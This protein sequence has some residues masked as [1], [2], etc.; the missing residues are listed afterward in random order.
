MM[1]RFAEAA[2][3]DPSDSQEFTLATAEQVFTL[4]AVR[5]EQFDA[6]LESGVEMEGKAEE[7]VCDGTVVIAHF[8][9]VLPVTMLSC[10]TQV[11][12]RV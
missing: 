5:D 1:A 8:I 10:G 4:Y 12:S 9:I 2:G 7:M 3:A 6:W 11:S